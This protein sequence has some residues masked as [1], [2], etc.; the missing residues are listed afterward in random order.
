MAQE[1]NLSEYSCEKA[2]RRMARDSFKP[3]KENFGSEMSDRQM[4]KK[5]DIP[6]VPDHVTIEYAGIRGGGLII[7]K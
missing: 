2:A 1:L 4:R 7:T 6:G 3:H 5:I